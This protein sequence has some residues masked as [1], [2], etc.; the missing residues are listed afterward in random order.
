LDT[1]HS[2]LTLLVVT[3]TRA[4]NIPLYL[5]FLAQQRL[6]RQ[7]QL[8]S[9]QISITTILLAHV[10]FFALGNSNAISSVDLSNGYNGISG[11]N[12]LGVGVLVFVSNWAGPIWW[13]ITGLLLAANSKSDRKGLQIQLAGSQ[14][15]TGLD[16]N[17]QRKR[18]AREHPLATS[19]NPD[20]ASADSNPPKLSP[21]LEYFTISTLFV[22]CSV[23]AVMLACTILR[24]HLFIWTVFSPKYLYSMAWSLGYH[25]LISL[26]LIGGLWSSVSKLE[27]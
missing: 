4:H 5:L 26:S 15:K 23:L 6:L 1:I 10:S 24:T 16:Y 9:L 14:H 20:S 22:S 2:L 25:L 27:P 7:L 3:Q 18:V 8:S 11:Y 13:S 17:Y 19:E 12:V 21:Y